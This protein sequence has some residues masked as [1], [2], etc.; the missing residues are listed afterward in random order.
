M[1]MFQRQERTPTASDDVRINIRFPVEI[2]RRLKRRAQRNNRSFQ[3]ELVDI[4]E[5]VLADEEKTSPTP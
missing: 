3:R 2:H 1:M 5:H 4:L